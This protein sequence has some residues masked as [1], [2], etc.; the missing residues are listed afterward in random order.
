MTAT[1]SRS[2]TAR[3]SR[4]KGADAE[5]DVAAYLRRSG[6]PDAERKQDNGWKSGDREKPDAGDVHKTPGLAWQVKAHMYRPMSSADIEA[7]L[8]A[9]VDQAVVAGA[10]YGVLIE[11]R[12]GKADPA[13]WWAWLPVSD[14][15]SLACA[16][17]TALTGSDLTA[18]VRTELCHLVAL[19][20][21]AGYG[22]P[23]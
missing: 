16:D 19:L 9:T 15:A 20:H 7:A 22:Q 17:A 8:A 5:R 4:R 3:E 10:D 11:R 13:H 21:R 1:K 6:W 12:E 2:A 18:P 23:E 14:L